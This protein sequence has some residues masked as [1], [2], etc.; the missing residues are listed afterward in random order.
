[1]TEKNV[2]IVGGGIAGLFSALLQVKK[3]NGKNT[4]LVEKNK[5]GGLLSCHAYDSFGKF[6]IGT[7]ILSETGNE[8][9]DNVLRPFY[10]SSDWNEMKGN[11][12]DIGGTILN[13]KLFTRSSAID[14]TYLSKEKSESII[15][16]IIGCHKNGVVINEHQNI[17]LY[18]KSKYGEILSEIILPIIESTFKTTAKL[19][20]IYASNFLPIFRVNLFDNEEDYFKLVKERDFLRDLIAYPN[21]REIPLELTSQNKC[22]YPKTIGIDLFIKNIKS[23]LIENQVKILEGASIKIESEKN[24]F[25]ESVK[26]NQKLVEVE[27]IV[28][29]AGLI[30]YAFFSN[31]KIDYE[32]LDKPLNTYV[33]HFVSN[34]KLN[35]SD[36]F[37]SYNLDENTHYYRL[38]SYQ[39]FTNIE[40]SNVHKF[41]IEIID[42]KLE[43]VEFK[44]GQIIN[45][46]KSTGILPEKAEILFSTVE[47]LTNGFP[48]PTINNYDFLNRLRG[49][50]NRSHSNVKIV[51]INSSEKL[52]FY[53]DILVDAYN[54]ISNTSIINDN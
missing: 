44:I 41:T 6:D 1:M 11:S 51:G 30:P 23:Y 4:V 35:C 9:V 47:T 33:C 40:D 12:R 32:K 18:L 25:I 24:K 5:L 42:E 31:V 45:S 50:L 7:H 20:S 28:W 27:S 13:N 39:N 21:Q 14:L 15:R 46:L 22:Y 17:E 36:T 52:F 10:S 19:L 53:R 54:K 48:V 38:T 37:Y 34:E 43:D 29:S 26:I 8:D 3:G 2:V 16:E 49:T